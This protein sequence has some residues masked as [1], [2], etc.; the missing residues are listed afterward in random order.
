VSRTELT[1]LTQWRSKSF[2]IFTLYNTAINKMSHPLRHS[3]S[4]ILV[5]M[6][7][8]NATSYVWI[9][10][11]TCHLASLWRYDGLFVQFSPSTEGYLSLTHSVGVNSYILDEKFGLKEL[12]TSLYHTMQSIFQYPE[13]WQMNTRTDGQWTDSL[14]AYAVLRYVAWP[15]KETETGMG[16]CSYSK[17]V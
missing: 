12:E 8:P 9:I 11:A 13:L 15:K 3:R 6:E 17:R 14:I 16:R 5:P 4:I 7:S 10:P 1:G 2:D